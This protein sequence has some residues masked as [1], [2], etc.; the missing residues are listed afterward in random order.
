MSATEDLAYVDEAYDRDYASD[1][2]S[3]YGA[4][5]RSRTHL[6]IDDGRPLDAVS[7]AALAWQIA[8]SPIMSPSYVRLSSPV[9]DV[10]CRGSE[11]DFELLVADLEVR[12]PWPSRLTP[13]DLGGSDVRD[14]DRAMSWAQDPGPYAE[15]ADDRSALLFTA[16][17]R[18]PLLH[19]LDLPAPECA[20]PVDVALAKQVVAELCRAINQQAAQVLSGL[21]TAWRGVDR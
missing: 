21:M 11:D 10:A 3:R 15:P 12:L 14:W 4:Y 16:R 18:L 9:F 1:R 2:Q 13:R 6:F 7:F 19:R 20:C 8:N 17:I 5:L